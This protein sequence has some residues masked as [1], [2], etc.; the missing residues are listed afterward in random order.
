MMTESWLLN[1][2]A[3]YKRLGLKKGVVQPWEDGL[4]DNFRAHAFEWW[5]FDTILDDGSKIAAC[6]CTTTQPFTFVGGAHPS[7]SVHITDS[8]GTEYRANHHKFSKDEIHFDTKKC[9][10]KLGPHVFS[11]DLQTY[12]IKA[13]PVDGLGFDVTLTKQG[14]SWRGDTGYIGFGHQSDGTPQ[15]YFTWTCMVPR[16]TAEGTLTINGRTRHIKGT[17]YHDH[18]WG[19][20]IQF[21]FLNNWLWSRQQTKDYGLVVF[22]FI[23]NKK[24]G[25]ARIPLVFLQDS[26]GDILFQSTKGVECEVLD[27]IDQPAAGCAFPKTT[28]YRFHDDKGQTLDYTLKVKQVL[29]DRNIYKGVPFFLRGMFAGSHP[30]YGRYLSSGDFTLTRADGTTIHDGGD[31]IY[32]FAYVQD[33]YRKLM[34]TRKSA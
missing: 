16:G 21:E 9:E 5:Y 6:Y 24:Y 15:K 10:V 11:G 20:T 14:A 1:S 19:D 28:R 7:V 30:K 13:E 29:D 18:Q 27:E 3:D 22:D 8:D 25:N 4:R 2:D 23:M 26:S 31:L 17:G 34:D 33:S 12:H 32:E